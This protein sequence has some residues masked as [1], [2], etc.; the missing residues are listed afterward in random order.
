MLVLS[1]YLE[2]STCSYVVIGRNK[3]KSTHGINVS[4]PLLFV[5]ILLHS[6]RLCLSISEPSWVFFQPFFS[7]KVQTC[8]VFPLANGS[9]HLSF[10]SVHSIYYP[11]CF[12]TIMGL[13]SAG[14]FLP[15]EESVFLPFV[16]WHYSVLWALSAPSALSSLD[17][18]E[19]YLLHDHTPSRSLDFQTLIFPP[20]LF[21]HVFLATSNCS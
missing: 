4:C 6:L 5:L 16:G 2:T 11:E 13:L 15:P 10:P 9:Q 3:C 7:G 17:H 14:F 18:A 12:W 19:K 20:S 1:T 21:C 8:G